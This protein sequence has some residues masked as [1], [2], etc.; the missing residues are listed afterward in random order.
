MQRQ[1]LESTQKQKRKIKF[2]IVKDT[3]DSKKHNPSENY[4]F[5]DEKKKLNFLELLSKK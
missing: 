3:N 4:I 2:I 1:K 5:L